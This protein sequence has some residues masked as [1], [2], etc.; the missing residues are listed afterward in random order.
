MEKYIKT[1]V[2]DAMSSVI[3]SGQESVT[4][5]QLKEIITKS[6][7][8]CLLSDKFISYINRQL[9]PQM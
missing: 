4:P 5:D 8:D 1:I 9:G 2:N 3:T 7:S 6:L